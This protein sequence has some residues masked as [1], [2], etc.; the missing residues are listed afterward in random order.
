MLRKFLKL[1]RKLRKM[2]GYRTFRQ[3]LR[4][5][6]ANLRIILADQGPLLKSLIIIYQYFL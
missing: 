2:F 3:I 5:I 1:T 4:I 6:F